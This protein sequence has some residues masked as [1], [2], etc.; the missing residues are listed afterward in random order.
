MRLVF[1]HFHSLIYCFVSLERDGDVLCNKS[2]NWVQG[3]GMRVGG[4][5]G[6][7]RL[8]GGLYYINLY[9]YMTSSEGPLKFV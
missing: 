7:E 2:V 6:G 5:T 3:R 8:V 1:K 4:T 9:M